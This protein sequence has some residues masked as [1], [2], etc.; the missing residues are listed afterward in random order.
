MSEKKIEFKDNDFDIK[1]K[2]EEIHQSN[3]IDSHYLKLLFEGY[4]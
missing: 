3:G 1:I 4:V 2:E